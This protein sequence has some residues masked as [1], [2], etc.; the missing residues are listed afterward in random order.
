MVEQNIQSVACRL[1]RAL[2]DVGA[3]LCTVRQTRRRGECVDFRV[4][5]DVVLAALRWLKKNNPL[6]KHVEISQDAV[7]VLGKDR[8]FYGQEFDEDVA[9]DAEARPKIDAGGRGAPTS[10]SGGLDKPC[11]EAC[12]KNG[13]ATKGSHASANGLQ[14]PPQAHTLPTLQEMGLVSVENDGDG[15]CF[16]LSLAFALGRRLSNEQLCASAKQLRHE[17]SALLTPEDFVTYRELYLN[18][19]EERE[20]RWMANITNIGQLRRFVKTKRFFADAIAVERLQLSQNVK[21]VILEQA[22]GGYRIVRDIAPQHV[23]EFRPEWYVLVLYIP[24][25]VHY[26]VLRREDGQAKFTLST[27]PTEVANAISDPGFRNT[28]YA[29]IPELQ[30]R[31]AAQPSPAP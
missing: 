25:A 3:S 14:R 30:A 17:F 11:V 18:N 21:V 4:R 26:E 10:S 24:E 22:L 12:S 1:P 6:Y 20:N 29:T 28:F 23:Q 27:L 5:S 15:D 9:E 13:K 19:P 16:F 8:Y 2:S 7:D 31:Q